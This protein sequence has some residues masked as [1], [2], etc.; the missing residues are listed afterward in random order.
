MPRRVQLQ[1][2]KLN[3]FCSSSAGEQKR[4][5]TSRLFIHDR[6]SKLA[7]LVD[8]GSDLTLV[9]P[10]KEE[11]LRPPLR[12]ML[13][14]ANGTV[15]T[16][17]GQRLM[18]INLDMRRDFTW[19]CTI[20]EVSGPIIG[21]DF[22]ETFNLAVDLRKSRLIDLNTHIFSYGVCRNVDPLQISVTTVPPI[23][24]PFQ[25]LLREFHSVT[26]PSSPLVKEELGV[27]H[28]IETKGPPLAAQA[29]RL[30]PEK[31]IQAK[32]EFEM[33][34]REGICRPS[35]S[36]WAS[37]L[38]LVP[39]KDGAW[40][41]CGDYR[42][43][44]SV[45][46]PDRY[47]VPHIQDA[48]LNMDGCTVF[49][50]IDLVRAYNQIPM[51]QDDIAKTAII[52]PFGLFEFLTM[53]FGL[54]NA[55]Q[56]FQRYIDTALRG[57][58]FA[59]CFIDDIRI[60]SRTHEE[61]I[62][63]VRLVLERLKKFGLQ[64]NVSKCVFAKPEIQFLGY[65]FNKDGIKPLPERVKGLLDVP[66]PTIA[67]ELTGFLAAINFYRRWIP[68][69]AANQSV[70]RSLIVGN[71]K[72][73][74]TPLVWTPATEK[75]FEQTKKDL[76]DATLLHHPVANSELILYTD[77]SDI[78]IGAALHQRNNDELQ[79][80]AF[81]SRKLKSAETRYSAYDRELLAIQQ[82]VS[83]FRNFIEGQRCIVYTDHKPLIYMY[84]KKADKESPRQSRA[85]DFISQ[86]VT[87][88]RHVPGQSNVMADLL[89]RACDDTKSLSTSS[90]TCPT[91]SS[92]TSATISA[93][94][95]TLD[96]DEVNLEQGIDDELVQLLARTDNIFTWKKCAFLTP[97]ALIWCDVS[98]GK[99]RP[100]LPE[101]L[102]KKFFD[103][104]HGLAHPGVRAT[105]KLM[106]DRFVWPS[107][108]RDCTRMARQCIH[109]QR[110]KIV[111]HNKPEFTTF[112]VPNERFNHINID[113]IGPLPPSRGFR[114]CLTCIDRYTRWPEV[115][116]IT[117]ITAETVARALLDGWIQRYGVPKKITTDRGRQFESFLFAELNRLLGITHLRTTAY[118]P[119]ANGMI[120]RLHRTIKAAIKCRANVSW[121]DVL[122]TILLSHRSTLKED[123]GATPA[124]MLFGTT[125][126]LPGEFF[127][128][129]EP[130]QPN[131]FV[132]Q[133]RIIM[134]QH[135]HRPGT[136]HN[137]ARESYVQPTL[138]TAKFVYVRVD[139]VK[140]PF[141]RPYEGP[142]KVLQRK[143]A[144]FIIEIKGKKEEIS[145]ERL[146]AAILDTDDNDTNTRHPTQTP[147]SSTDSPTSATP[148]SP[149]AAPLSLPSTLPKA[150]VSTPSAKKKTVTFSP[151]PPKTTRLG[152]VVRLPAKLT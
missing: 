63:H 24:D 79:P 141:T 87:E 91:T 130:I 151:L 12:D 41:P 115:I 9:P 71:K 40:R 73:D 94:T 22:L 150:P 118:H 99:V 142:F 52:T 77:A 149:P 18:R 90:T 60:A 34:V 64:I 19:S 57:L 15:I 100:Y 152:R 117:D 107:I 109:C 65:N 136:N 122:P 121:T 10:T 127:D 72:N 92:T 139:Y 62:Q 133:L 135:Q 47:P 33:M 55:A 2:K 86:F 36:S 124:E 25:S 7:F 89:S 80:L 20:A 31:Y 17:Y 104:I 125:V 11:R 126:R 147:L 27:S 46:V 54:R 21:A 146:R 16:V 131:E 120:E 50:T 28:F 6:N 148:V 43:L 106:T 134:R 8:T 105:V 1:A 49:S 69:A 35:K 67:K 112:V 66:Q 81:F 110:S 102:R 101:S 44:N 114:Y 70:L 119:C 93:T 144:T 61:H 111:R 103:A 75:A 108:R 56:T 84:T 5:T 95:N 138:A 3:N 14:A 42:R 83:H 48:V 129:T 59:F 51:N 4:R 85:I 128:N 143:S 23:G 116:P 58:P 97:N 38:H 74:R 82:A 76:A 32:A 140:Q 98:H 37:P 123:L 113:L 145:I 30:S 26:L 88:I 53:T 39:K 132:D 96:Y 137:T 13:F 45:T 29:R 68:H 78:A